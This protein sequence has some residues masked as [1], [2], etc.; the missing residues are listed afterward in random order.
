MTIYWIR[1]HWASRQIHYGW[2]GSLAV[3][4]ECEARWWIANQPKASKCQTSM[5]LILRRLLARANKMFIK[6]VPGWQDIHQRV[7]AS[8]ATN[9]QCRTCQ[10]VSQGRPWL[11]SRRADDL[12]ASGRR[13]SSAP[14]LLLKSE[15]RCCCDRDLKSW[16][17]KP[18]GTAGL[19]PA[20]VTQCNLKSFWKMQH[21]AEA[22]FPLFSK[23]S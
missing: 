21:V 10:E 6:Y 19:S 12:T 15:R 5:S 11:H 17:Q 23:K 20:S 16:N 7:S 14:P 1:K 2:N 9:C 18:S 8:P 22:Y 4:L 13:S 3:C